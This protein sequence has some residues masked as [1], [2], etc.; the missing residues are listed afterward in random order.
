MLLLFVLF[1][2]AVS[3]ADIKTGAVPRVAFLAAFACFG[4]LRFLAAES[5]RPPLAPIAGLLL[6]L[7]VFVLALMVSGG[8]LGWA[9]VWYSALIGLVRGPAWWYPSIAVACAAALVFIGITRKRRIPFIPF[10]AAGSIT[11]CVMQGWLRC[12]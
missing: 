6:G 11:S 1:S 8:R 9:D 3:I 10:L 4:A 12:G 2:L 5:Y 7:A